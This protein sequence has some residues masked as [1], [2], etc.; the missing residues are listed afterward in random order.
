MDARQP[1]A[2]SF[3]NT[4]LIT[5]H[6]AMLQRRL[7]S[8]LAVKTPSKTIDR[9]TA[10]ESCLQ[11]PSF[12]NALLSFV[13]SEADLIK[14]QSSQNLTRIFNNRLEAQSLTAAIATAGVA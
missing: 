9:R 13:S 1:T 3:Q 11:D 6:S 10:L 7:Q 4:G 5:S 12:M 14:L 2:D 8:G